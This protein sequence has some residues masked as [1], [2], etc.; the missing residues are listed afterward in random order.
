MLPLGIIST[1]EKQSLHSVS[2]LN[3]MQTISVNFYYKNIDFY[4]GGENGRRK[5]LR[6]GRGGDNEMFLRVYM[7]FV[8]E[9]CHFQSSI[10]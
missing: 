9:F 7:G 2:H 3:F 6:S 5:M 8:R 1:I 4:G 10:L